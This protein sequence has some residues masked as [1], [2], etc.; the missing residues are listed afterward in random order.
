MGGVAGQQ[1]PS[2]PIGIGNPVV[3]PESRSPDQF[4][5]NCATRAEA[6]GVQDVLD[7]LQR[8]LLRCVRGRRDDAVDAAGQRCQHI[9][10]GH[11]VEQDHFVIGR[12][13]GQPDVGEREGFGVL[14]AGEA[15]PGLLA[16]GAVRAVAAHHKARPDDVFVVERGCDAV[17]ILRQTGQRLWPTT[18]PPSPASRSTSSASVV[19]CESI[20]VY[21]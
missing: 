13:A 1:Q 5:D 8:R 19:A 3:D 6:A 17:A 12:L 21:G 16:H 18:S 15:D 4:G 10:A 20:S 9:K 7:E 14:A 2:D 11:R